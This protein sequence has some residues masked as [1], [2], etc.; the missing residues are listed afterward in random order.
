MTGQAGLGL[1]AGVLLVLG[2]LAASFLIED[3][4]PATEAARPSVEPRASAD[5]TY[6]EQRRRVRVEVLNGAGDAGAAAQV[7]EVLRAAGFDVKTY[8]NADRFD[9]ATSHVLD[10]SGRPGAAGAVAA[11]LG[12]IGVVERLD[13]ELYLDASV[14]LGSDWRDLLSPPAR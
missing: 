1:A 4:A 11:A 7:T 8:G 2:A 9:Y 6:D 3:G 12:G 14:I 10:R 5:I 13:G